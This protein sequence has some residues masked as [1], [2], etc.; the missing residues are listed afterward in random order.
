[1]HCF[2][3]GLLAVIGVL[4]GYCSIAFGMG[5]LSRDVI[6]WKLARQSYES[7]GWK[8]TTWDYIC[9]GSIFSVLASVG[10]A[11]STGIM[12]IIFMIGCGITHGH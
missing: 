7:G 8:G 5:H 11:I 4:G 1:M 3:V 2:L 12:R 10:F 9:E 6:K